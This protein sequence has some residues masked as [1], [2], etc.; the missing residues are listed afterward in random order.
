MNKTNQMSRLSYLVLL[1]LSIGAANGQSDCLLTESST[2]NAKGLE[3]QLTNTFNSEKKIIEEFKQV[4]SSPNGSYT[5]R[6]TFDYNAKGYLS[7]TTEFVNDVVK[8]VKNRTYDN[9]GNLISETEG[10]ET[11]GT[12]I[13]NKLTTS[14]TGSVKLYFGENNTVSGTEIIEKDASGNVITH[15]VLNSENRV[16]SSK[17]YRY[18]NESK[19]IYSKN[20]DV[21]G[22]M[23]E[24]TFTDYNAQGQ[25]SKDST[26]LNEKLIAKTLYEYT[27]GFLTTKT[28]I[29]RNNK[30][31]YVITY[32]N[33][34]KGKV[35]E[36]RFI[37]NGEL[38]SRVENSYDE[39]DNKV[40][41]KRYNQN[42]QLLRTKTW[43]YNCPN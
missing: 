6:K 39:F 2:S 24:E 23:L 42:N 1:V 35:T 13:I 41:E 21:V 7:K 31:D 3:S 19:I 32:D 10:L 22:E 11:S 30:V 37:Y 29:G 12:N 34:N 17:E 26:Y 28:R 33:N 5:Q 16:N 9:L 4:F 38:L 14:G 43:E 20:D 8:S 15:N 40:L 18:N 25:I 36:E 27:N